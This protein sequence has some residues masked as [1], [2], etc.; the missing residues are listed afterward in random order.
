MRQSTRAA[1]PRN[2]SVG[3]NPSA[4]KDRCIRMDTNPSP[5]RS[6][7]RTL[8]PFALIMFLGYSAV[9][10]PLST[11]PLLVHEQLGYGTGVVGIVIGLAPVVTLLTRQ[12]AGRLA[13][14]R[15]P[16]FGLLVGLLTTS[17]SGIAY[18][19]A[20]LLPH[21][22]ALAAVLVGR[23]L[24]GLGDSLFTT[25]TNTWMVTAAGPH[26]AGRAMSWAGIAM[27]GALAVGAPLGAVMGLLGFAWV[28]AAVIVMPLLALP[29]ALGLTALP[30]VIARPASFLGVVGKIWP[31]GL[32]LV[33]ASGGV[34]T[35]AAFLALRFAAMD[36]GGAGL[37]LTGFGGVYIL[38]RLLFAGLPDRIGGVRVATICLV[39]EACGLALIGTA[40]S[41]LLA[42]LGTALTGLGY[43][44][45]FPALGVEVVRR[46]PAES[47]GMA[48][49]AFLACFDLGLGAAGPAMGF[50][51]AG[52]GLPSAFLGA[53]VAAL[54]SLALVWLTRGRPRSAG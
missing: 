41:P 32:A 19:V 11:L 24:L 17:S 7:T 53:A 8:L 1:S 51:A 43:S 33:L 31:Q 44:M 5:A 21:G 13:D 25:A 18:L 3:G 54:V 36:W 27:Y 40:G 14:R 9:G 26:N 37:A 52:H 39:I 47:R 49:G 4:V 10:L 20:S 6:V 15:G 22:P 16:K 45:V 29:L 46:V 38:S 23:V 42:F 50:L 35:I 28:A 2:A 48:L 34:G 12:F 30:V